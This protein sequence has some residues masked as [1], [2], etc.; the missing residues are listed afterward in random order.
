MNEQ[1]K[2]LVSR[3]EEKHGELNALLAKGANITAEDLSKA[4]TLSTE[5]NE[6][7]ST[8]QRTQALTEKAAENHSWLNQAVTPMIHDGAKLV[9]S[10]TPAGAV[11][12]DRKSGDLFFIDGEPLLDRAKIEVLRSPEYKAAFKAYLRTG[13]LSPSEAKALSE[14]ADDQGGYLAPEDM[15]ARL[16]EKRPTPTRLGDM[17]T[18]VPCSRDALTIPRVKYTGDDL[19]TTGIR[20][21]VTGEVPASAT[22]SRVNFPD[23]TGNNQFGALRFQVYTQTMSLA[24]SNDMIEDAV[25][26]VNSWVGDKFRQTVDLYKDNMILN[27]L[28]GNQPSGILLNPGGTD[29]PAVVAMG[30]PITGDGL[31]DV[32]LSLP[33]QYEDA[34]RYV[35]NKTNTYRTIRKLKDGDGRYLFGSGLQDSGLATGR[36]TDLAGYPFTFSGFAPNTGTGKYPVIF[37]NLGGYYWIQRVDLVITVLREILAQTNQILVMARL[38]VGGGVAE[39]WMFEIGHQA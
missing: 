30:D 33:E 16:I 7:K 38:R 19:Y 13:R 14:G 15:L 37:G 2:A 12:M 32:S 20:V 24:L 25:F 23:A 26:P 22:S 17:V 11:E 8:I 9:G 4:D 29:Q 10:G 28:G 31:M 1:W 34:A 5:I 21:Q 3:A 36:P 35:F 39:P 6:I 27:G 18:T